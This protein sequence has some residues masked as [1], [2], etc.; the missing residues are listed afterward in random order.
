MDDFSLIFLEDSN[1]SEKIF[2]SDVHNV[3]TFITAH[4]TNG[5]GKIRKAHSE[6]FLIVVQ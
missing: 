4:T 5:H 3:G 2:L 6:K 1:C